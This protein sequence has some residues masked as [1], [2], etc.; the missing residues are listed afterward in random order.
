MKTL[1][2]IDPRMCTE[3]Q[4]CIN[5]CKKEHGISRGKKSSTLPI[6]CLQ[7]HPEKAPC[8]RICPTGAI[9]EEDGTLI[10]DDDACLLCRLCMIACPVGMLVVDDEKKSMQKCTLCLDSDRIIPACVEACKDNVLKIFSI[11][12]LEDLKKDISFADVLEEAMKLYQD[13]I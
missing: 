13:R 4:E 6:F 10:I 2:V 12:D 9:K 5:A 1:M 3:C 8:A 11:E 7:C